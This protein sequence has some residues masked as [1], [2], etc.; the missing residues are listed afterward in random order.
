[1]HIFVPEAFEK[2]SDSLSLG[3][4]CRI[5]AAGGYGFR[6][7]ISRTGRLTNP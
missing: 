1:M 7:R 4:L 3:W 6:R 2:H 5:V